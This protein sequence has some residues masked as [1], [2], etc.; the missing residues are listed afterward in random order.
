[1][2]I[3]AVVNSVRIWGE[4]ATWPQWAR[5]PSFVLLIGSILVF[6]SSALILTVPYLRHRWGAWVARRINQPPTSV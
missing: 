2:P 6:V 1:L 3:L 5:L 4:I